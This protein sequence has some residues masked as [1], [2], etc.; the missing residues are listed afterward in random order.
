[1]VSNVDFAE[2]ILEAGGAPVPGDMQGKSLVRILSGEAP[3]DWRKTFYYHYYENTVHGV[4]RH[5]GVR[6][7]RYTLAYYYTKDEWELFDRQKDPRQMRSVYKQPE[8]A[9]VVRELKSELARLRK[10]LKVPEKDP[11]KQ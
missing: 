5:Y 10:E 3:K 6:T 8:Y 9:P 11:D 1:M 7:D 2:T 4:A